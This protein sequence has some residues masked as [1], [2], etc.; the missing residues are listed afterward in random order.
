MYTTP[1]VRFIRYNTPEW[2][3]IARGMKS[4]LGYYEADQNNFKCSQLWVQS[5]IP[6]S[7]NT[8]KTIPPYDRS[9]GLFASKSRSHDY[10]HVTSTKT[11]TDVKYPDP[12]S[13]SFVAQCDGY[14]F[15]YQQYRIPEFGNFNVRELIEIDD[16]KRSIVCTLQISNEDV[17]EEVIYYGV[18]CHVQAIERCNMEWM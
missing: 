3:F 17:T 9:Y 2:R 4:G 15:L 8:P 10:V 7:K 1:T 11:T 5:R 6:F 18:T 12:S 14:G 13:D 16:D